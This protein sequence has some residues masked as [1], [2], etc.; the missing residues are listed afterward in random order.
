MPAVRAM[1]RLLTALLNAML[2][3]APHASCNSCTRLPVKSM[4]ELKQGSS[5][6][7]AEARQLRALLQ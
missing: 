3:S 6:M 1:A 4:L 2:L 5:N 7:Q